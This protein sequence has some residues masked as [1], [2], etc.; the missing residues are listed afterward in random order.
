MAP[1]RWRPVRAG[2]RNVWE[3]DDQV[4]AFADGRLILRGPNGSGKS[5]ALALL[6]PFLL[7]GT[8]SAAAMDP[9]AGGRSM[10]SLLLGVRR[11]DADARRYRHDTRLGY[12]WMELGRRDRAGSERFLTIGCGARATA[13]SGDARSWFFVTERRVGPEVDLA[14]GGDL[15][16]RPK[17]AE[18]I[19]ADAVHD[20]AEAY[21]AAVDRAVFGLGADRQQK[22]VSL[23]RVL[24]R[25]QLAGKLDLT[26]LS[27]VLS[28]GLPA[29]DGAVLDDVASS[30][31]DL[32]ST[33][34]DLAE[35]QAA[36]ATLDAFL[37]T[38]AAYLAGEALTR[39]AAV[40]DG[41]DARR[42][43][44][45]RVRQADA[46]VGRVA[47]ELDA[48]TAAR[49]DTDL[50]HEAADAERVAVIESPAFRDAT[51]LREVEA[52]AR[53]ADEQL[54]AATRRR[55]E[56]VTGAQQ[57]DAEAARLGEVAAE[58]TTAA[59]R[60]LTEVRDAADA[61][62]LVWTLSDDQARDP[63][64]LASGAMVAERSRRDDI[65][66]VRAA[67]S[68]LDAARRDHDR[69]E[70][71]ASEALVR[72][73]AATAEAT[74]AKG[75]ADR[76][77]DALASAVG[78]WAADAPGLSAADRST[79]VATVAELGEPGQPGLAERFRELTTTA[80]ELLVESRVGALA[81]LADLDAEMAQLQAERQ[82][83][84]AEV[85]PGPAAPTWRRSDRA[86]RPGAPL[87]ACCDFAPSVPD[88]DR[89]G[90][91]A[92]LDAG[93]IL[94]A[95]VAPADAP[96]EPGTGTIDSWLSPPD[97]A[98]PEPAGPP[99]A[100]EGAGPPGVAGVAGGTGPPGT[101]AG[102][103]LH[104]AEGPTLADVLVPSVPD[105]SGLDVARVGAVLR[106]IGLGHLGVAVD[107]DGGFVL[108]PLR[109]TAAKDRPEFIG[110]TA[111]AD[112]RRRRLAEIGQAL[113]VLAAR[114]EDQ[115]A[116][117]DEVVARLAELD[118]APATLPPSV[119]LEHALATLRR[120]RSDAEAR[121][122]A[123][124]AA[125]AEEA[126]AAVAAA[127]AGEALTR[128]AIARRLGG[129]AAALE[130]AEQLV[131]GFA[132]AT[133]RAVRS[134]QQAIDAA[135]RATDAQGRADAAARE[136]DVR[137]SEWDDAGREASGLRAR[138]DTLRARLGPDAE[139]PLLALERCEA[140]LRHLAGARR[141][142]EDARAQLERRKGSVEGEVDEAA[143]ARTAAADHLTEVSQR[144]TVLRRADLLAVAAP[145]ATRS[146]AAASGAAE[147]GVA[148]PGTAPSG[149][150][151]PGLAP[152]G[153]D[154]PGAVPSGS[155][156][157]APEAAAPGVDPSSGAPSGRD[158]SG[159]VPSGPD[160]DGPD[161]FAREP[162]DVADGLP[163]D[164]VEFASWL[165]RRV[166]GDVP[167][168]EEQARRVSALDRAQKTLLD[169]L[170]HGY[171]PSLAH[172]DGITTVQVTSE[173]GTFGL[174][175]LADELAAQDEQLRAYL[176]EGDREVFERFL[177]NRV[178][179][180]LRRL[181]TDADEFVAGVNR[182][183][184]GAPTA[185]GLRV[186]L[187]W[188]LGVDDPAVRDAVRLLR[189]DTEQMGD[190]ERAE[191][192]AFFE[193]VIRQQRAENP[194]AGYRAALEA[195]LDYR[196]WHEF[197]PYLR[198]ADGARTR[199]TRTRYRELSGG[200]QAVALH[201]P[202]FAAAAAHYARAEP[203]APRLV[204][205]DE[206]FAGIDEAMRGELMGLTVRFDLD[207]I[208]TGHELWGA[209]V[210]VPAV[211]VH[212][213]LR[214]PPAEGVSVFSLRWD[215][216]ALVEEPDPALDAA[217][218]GRAP[219]LDPPT[220][221]LFATPPASGE[222]S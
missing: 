98:A 21:R 109:G 205:L 175:V 83:V 203:T 184:A 57:A 130:T 135:E 207:L 66:V 106:A 192:R 51:S 147:P 187:G 88:A 132:A 126:E 219:G 188:E 31:D 81:V 45:A 161:V 139:A 55:D 12:V 93:G 221:G 211:A 167:S 3:Y 170:H 64:R 157:D 141:E 27:E 47:T 177:L 180:E 65:R 149:V 191:L 201:L 182:A 222:R 28:G 2:I 1:D 123:A 206:A 115:G 72:A 58:R 59:E 62:D 146:D 214:R 151:A 144:L 134:R 77:R 79:L 189:R 18:A 39:A 220:D 73:D 204:A 7:D 218:P 194:T 209:Y 23:I 125:Q 150:A 137:R 181:L 100:G 133:G 108:G 156:G 41:A 82:Q 186:E 74:R 69:A 154:D 169:D 152:C 71:A 118:A 14:P 37:P 33:Q 155:N 122:D 121:A 26:L 153:R 40:A 87:W 212:D 142:L 164:P 94:D 96:P 128:Q 19:G 190:S 202:L 22:L 131:A 54:V 129:E 215:G 195:A 61:V 35:L 163:S 43:A 103:G 185:S 102:A 52:A 176:T 11:D 13:Q 173:R 143:R 208:M 34:R 36:R 111:R 145:G 172:D 113:T 44:E 15:L 68:D 107:R 30:L 179:H 29:L 112:R 17:L 148:S 198:G 166:D 25:P 10:R 116:A 120:S 97:P 9:F 80:R 5:N 70:R 193:R 48:N 117:R 171:D 20:T 165:T 49:R 199:L 76:E 56:A 110:A 160:G 162:A 6:F 197:R 101:A 196:S 86:S 24:R 91:E 124:A 138:V 99:G 46:A 178:A 53:R 168:A 104:D 174:S 92:A 119:G 140:R 16:T 127:A 38:Y 158:A 216:H 159:A 60:A 67:R 32:E 213:L 217:G 105:T 63:D 183:L 84:E 78:T 200:E 75:E 114:L 210:E 4:F 90:L 42:R 8:M 89:A 50:A 95:W 85:D 136:L